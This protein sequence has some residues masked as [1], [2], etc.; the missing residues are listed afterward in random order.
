MPRA[1]ALVHVTSADA[2]AP[3]E[4]EAMLRQLQASRE[5]VD[6]KLA[7]SRIQL[8]GSSAALAAHELPDGYGSSGEEE[9][10]E[11]DEEGSGDDGSDDEGS[12][13]M[14]S[15]DEDEDEDGEQ[16]G[17]CLLGPRSPVSA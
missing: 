13:G 5:A 2:D 3:G 9:G 14:G 15:D 4:G 1:D 12:E 17:A 16:R 6:E 8:F 7:R 11:D 10:S